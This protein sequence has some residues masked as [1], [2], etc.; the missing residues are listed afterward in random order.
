MDKKLIEKL[1]INCEIVS[2]YLIEFLRQEITK[3]GII[4]AV[5]GLSGGIDSAVVAYLAKEALGK[6]NVYAILMPYKLSSKESVEDALKVVK[7]TGINYKIFEITKP[8][9]AYIDQFDDIDKLRK[10]NIFA[11][12]RMITL[13]DHSSLYKALVVGT[14]NKTELLLG[15]GTWYGD[16]ASSLNPIGDLYKNQ[17]YQLARYFKVPES[18]IE[19]KPSADLWVGQSD[20]D[21]LGFSYDE[22]DVILY[23]LYDLHYTI[24]DIA[25][26]G[27]SRELVKGIAN[28]VKRN[29]FKRLPPIIAKVSKRTINIDFRYL[30][31]WG[32]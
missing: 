6:E 9:D 24:D 8:A 20:E 21:E 7:D 31:D 3:T 30:R 2:S 16:M 15:Y 4:K 25:S 5:L 10:G 11:R 19:K 17:I 26:L 32:L 13:F 22:A 27:F 29:Q 14:S 1:K 18:I 23:H 28:R 12:M